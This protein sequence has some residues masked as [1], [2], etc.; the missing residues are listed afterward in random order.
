MLFWY[1]ICSDE[2]TRYYLI[3]LYLSL[4][5]IYIGKHTYLKTYIFINFTE[6]KTQYKTIICY[7][8]LEY[9]YVWIQLKRDGALSKH[10]I[11]RR[12]SETFSY[13]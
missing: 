11:Q 6:E 9:T 4:L 12:L 7:K 1:I 5:I 3:Y 13:Q 8:I 2:N 10:H